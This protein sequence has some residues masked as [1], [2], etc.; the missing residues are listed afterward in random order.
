[1]Q[2]QTYY[3]YWFSLEATGNPHIDA[4]LEAIARAGKASH[5]TE[6]WNDDFWGGDEPTHVEKIQAAAD[7]AAKAWAAEGE[8]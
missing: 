3:A 2:K 7:A 4:I 5:H 6:G 8:Q 1:M